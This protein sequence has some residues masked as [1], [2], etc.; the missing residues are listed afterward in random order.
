MRTTDNVDDNAA[1]S[2]VAIPLNHQII[3]CDVF[4]EDYR[5]S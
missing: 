3:L 5:Y 2:A 1:H 4:I